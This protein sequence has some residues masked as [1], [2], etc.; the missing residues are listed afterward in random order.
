MTTKNIRTMI[1][2]V[3]L[4]FDVMSNEDLIIKIKEEF[5]VS[6]NSADLL[7]LHIDLSEL[8]ISNK[9]IDNYDRYDKY[10]QELAYY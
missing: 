6:V 8:D 3:E 10:R 9:Q 5:G 4:K 7:S 2:L 1:S